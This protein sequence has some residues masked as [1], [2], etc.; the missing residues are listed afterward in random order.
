MTNSAEESREHETAQPHDLSG[1]P[2]GRVGR[3]GQVGRLWAAMAAN[4]A[5]V[6]ALIGVGLSARSIGVFAE[7]ADY[8][9]DAGAIGLSLF[10]VHLSRRSGERGP[11]ARNL[12]PATVAAAVN[13]GWLLAAC[14]LVIAEAADRLAGGVSEVR[15][16]PVLVVSG[17]A[18]VAMTAV[19]LVLGG[20][21]DDGDEED[22]EGLGGSGGPKAGNPIMLNM[23]AVLL[24]TIAD[25]AAAAGVA[26]A[27]GII[28]IV[29]G[30]Y[31][32]DPAVAL[33]IATV[34]GYHALRLSVEIKGS[35]R[36]SP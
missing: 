11:G 22:S 28:Y 8:L 7:G 24:D 6:G 10:A 12:S 23:R 4:L 25:A 17:V 13:A 3:V 29:H 35:L 16:L 34:V 32:L 9:A 14:L 33:V 20:D 5:L 18:A 21:G 31:W 2:A 19:A 1:P 15:G 36:S 27:G 26:V 30:L